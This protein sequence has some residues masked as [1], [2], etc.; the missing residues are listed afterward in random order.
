MASNCC[1][2]AAAASVFVSNGPSDA[3]AV[4][5]H[6]SK[7][8]NLSRVCYI[9]TLKPLNFFASSSIFVA[10]CSSKAPVRVVEQKISCKIVPRPCSRYQLSRYYSSGMES[11]EDS[12]N[13][14]LGM[15]M[16]TAVPRGQGHFI[17][18]ETEFLQPLPFFSGTYN[19]YL[20]LLCQPA[21]TAPMGLKWVQKKPT[22]VEAH[23]E[24]HPARAL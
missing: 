24:H 5:L 15:E 6:A 23:M 2:C 13:L 11:K 4:V 17:H 20:Y 3:L 7:P 9:I 21:I 1:S 22:H 8:F 12:K 18:E 19:C 16:N 14:G 10:I